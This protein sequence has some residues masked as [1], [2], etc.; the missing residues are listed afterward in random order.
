MDSSR[1][2]SHLPPLTRSFT[3]KHFDSALPLPSAHL[4]LNPNMLLPTTLLSL[5]SFI[6]LTAPVVNGFFKLPC[7]NP[8]IQERADPII[9]PGKVA[10]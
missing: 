6:S 8:L 4:D 1:S 7:D 5:V 3:L 9:S 10:G 2:S